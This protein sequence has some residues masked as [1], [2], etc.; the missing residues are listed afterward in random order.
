[1]STHDPTYGTVSRIIKNNFF[2]VNRWLKGG[3]CA[4]IIG[5]S[6]ISHIGA[7]TKSSCVYSK[8]QLNNEN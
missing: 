5:K 3:G 1:M 4:F 2:Q 6:A 7:T 8:V